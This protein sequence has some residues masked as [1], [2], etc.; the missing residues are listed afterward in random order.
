[1]TSNHKKV[2]LECKECGK[3]L[4][5]N[6]CLRKHTK[7]VHEPDKSKESEIECSKCGKKLLRES[8][9]RHM[10]NVHNSSL[11]NSEH[12]TSDH[13]VECKECGKIVS[14]NYNLKRHTKRFHKPEKSKASRSECKTCGKELQTESIPRHMRRVHNE[15]K[16]RQGA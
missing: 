13:K 9:A 2:K 15:K 6:H 16:I 1:M 4:S 3:I 14:S 11:N 8:I 7:R 12:E 10:R 5:S